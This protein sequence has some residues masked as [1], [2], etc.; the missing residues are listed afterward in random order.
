MH[1]LDAPAAAHE[2]HGQPVEQFG[3]RGLLAH[4]AEI[5]Q[6]RDDALPEMVA[7]D[8]I[9]HHPRGQR[10]FP[11]AEPFGQRPSSPRSAAI[12]R[13]I[14]HWWIAVI[15]YADKSGLH[16]WSAA[17]R[18]AADQEIRRRRLIAARPLK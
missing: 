3:V 17:F 13:R 12:R 7:P 14:F 8:A 1:L 9:D 4:L 5:I 15:D 16:Q 11:R 2:L 6:R 10:I 18:I